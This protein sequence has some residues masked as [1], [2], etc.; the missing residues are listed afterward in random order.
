MNTYNWALLFCT[1]SVPI[2]S[3][4]PMCCLLRNYSRLELIKVLHN[5]Q[6]KQRI[7]SCKL[8]KFGGN[9]CKTHGGFPGGAVVKNLPAS[10]GDARDSG[11]IPGL[12]RF[13]GGGIGNPLQYSCVENSKD[14][15]S[16]QATVHGVTESDLTE[17]THLFAFCL[18]KITHSR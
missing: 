13:L 17:L 11:S 9:K 8:M 16:W 12:G 7:F 4:F 5:F 1:H 18:V 15:T 6:S 2:F 10:A 14:R 3:P